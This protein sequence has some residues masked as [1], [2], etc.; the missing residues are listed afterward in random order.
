MTTPSTAGCVSQIQHL[1]RKNIMASA[2]SV[3]K[4]DLQDVIDEVIDV[5]D[6]A[7][8]PEATREDLA[9]AVGQA[10]DT[11]RGEDEDDTADDSDDLDSDDS[12]DAIDED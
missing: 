12:D 11:L 4:S 1:R 8:E 7:Y 3:T 2:N 6:D 5:L 10:L 9:E